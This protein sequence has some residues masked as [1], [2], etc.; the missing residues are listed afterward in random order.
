MLHWIDLLIGHLGPARRTALVLVAANLLPLLLVIAGL[1]SLQQVMLL[2]WLENAVIGLWNVAKMLRSG[3]PPFVLR[4]F[5]ACFFTAHFG[6]FFVV[7]GIFLMLL[8]EVADRTQQHRTAALGV[9]CAAGQLVADGACPGLFAW[10][11]GLA[12]PFR[13]R[14]LALGQQRP[15]DDE[16]LRPG[17]TAASDAAGLGIRHPPPWR[18]P[19]A[20]GVAGAD[21]NRPRS[22]PA[23]VVAS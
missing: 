4:L 15:A 20:A 14:R 6:I 3:S 2:Y 9:A 22:R 7:H 19:G 8:P 23:C 12:F 10:L 1:W 18:K 11:F 13:P 16:T 17:D 5:L 21:E